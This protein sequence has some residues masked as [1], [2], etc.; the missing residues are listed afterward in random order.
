M[1]IT[2][3]GSPTVLGVPLLPGCYVDSHWGQYGPD[4]MA[5]LLEAFGLPIAGADD[6]R[7][8]SRMAEM[9]ADRGDTEREATAWDCYHWAADALE[10]KA[11]DVTEGG[12]W[13]WN[14]GDFMLCSYVCTEC[15]RDSRDETGEPCDYCEDADR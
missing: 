4:R 12:Y 11:N 8:W 1:T 5:D 14:D 6:P 2:F 3:Q 15:G 13:T 7:R 10:Q 9:Y